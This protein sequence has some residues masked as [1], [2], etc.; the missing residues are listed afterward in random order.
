MMVSALTALAWK[1]GAGLPTRTDME[2][3]VWGW[4]NTAAGRGR[5]DGNKGQW[6]FPASPFETKNF[7]PPIPARLFAKQPGQSAADF[8]DVGAGIEGGDAEPAFAAGTEAG[9]RRDDH[10]GIAQHLVEHSPRIEAGRAADP[11]IGRVHAAE[12]RQAGRAGGF[13]QEIGRASCR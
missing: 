3:W 11:D 12:H 6:K 9:A 5:G 13:A 1:D 8:L 2:W 4:E 7:R 10:L